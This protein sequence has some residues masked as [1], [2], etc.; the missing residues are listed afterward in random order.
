MNQAEQI[1]YLANIYYLARADSNFEV[2]EDYMLQEI[3]KDIGAGYL[4]TRKALDMS[5]S[6]DFKVKIPSRLS[7][8][9][10]T[11]EDMLLIAYHDKKL[12]QMEKKV[13]LTFA[14][15]MGIGKKQFDVI[16]EEM[17]ERLKKREG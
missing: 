13:I 9:I 11:L 16:R 2:E 7:E 12:D 10:R 15:E 3:A 4:E 8:R 14:K 17:K 6:A 1:Q 5:M